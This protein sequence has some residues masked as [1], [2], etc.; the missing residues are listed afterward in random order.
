MLPRTGGWYV[1]SRRTFGEKAGFVA[2]AACRA[3]DSE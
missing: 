3:E 2:G 1:Y